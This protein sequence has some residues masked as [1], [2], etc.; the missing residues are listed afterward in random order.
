MIDVGLSIYTNSS[1]KAPGPLV[2]IIKETYDSFCT[3]FRTIKPI[4]YFDP[5]P[6]V[7]ASEEYYE[8]LI[9][10]FDDVR[11]CRSLADGNYLSIKEHTSPFIFNLEHDWR[12]VGENISHS[13]DQIVET[14]EN[15]AVPHLRFNK[16]SN[17]PNKGRDGELEERMIGD[18]PVCVTKWVSNNPNIINRN[19]YRTHCVSFIRNRDSHKPGDHE[20]NMSKTGYKSAIYG[21]LHHP[22]T[23]VHLD[24]RTRKKR[25]AK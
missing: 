23:T 24:G 16:R 25:G 4:V 14:M 10:M 9:H 15:W 12:F 2:D 17:R 13:L 1:D 21:G 11:M 20:R 7:D 22:A 19:M 6:N 18:I 5:M 3:T 8:H